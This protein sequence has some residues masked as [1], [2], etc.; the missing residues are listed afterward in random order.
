MYG[1]PISPS[2]TNSEFPGGLEAWTK[3]LR[4]NLNRDLPVQK[5]A[6]PGKYIDTLTFI[7]DKTGKIRNVQSLNDPGFGTKEEAIRVLLKG[8][9]WKPA[10]QNGKAVTSRHNKTITWVITEE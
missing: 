1:L 10:M 4:Q 8:P 3:Y 9:D 6:P 5:G 7:V 2:K